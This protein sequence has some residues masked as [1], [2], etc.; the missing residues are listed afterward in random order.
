MSEKRE[1]R[2]K[3]MTSIARKLNGSFWRKRLW[4]LLLTDFIVAALVC[5][6]YLYSCEKQIYSQAKMSDWVEVY[7]HA[8]RYFT[9]TDGISWRQIDYVIQPAEM[10]EYRFPVTDFLEFCIPAAVILVILQG[11]HL[12]FALF[13]T[14]EIRRKLKPINDLAVRAE[15]MSSISFD[16]GKFTTLEHAI[17]SISPDEPEAEVHTGDQDLQSIEVA[18][19]NLLHHM[20]ESQQQ[21]ARFVSDASH[22]LRTP[23]AVIEGYVNLLDRWGKEDEAVLNESIEALKQESAHMK[24]LVEQLLFLA[25]GDSG[26]N[27]LHQ[28]SFDLNDVVKEVFEESMMIEEG[29]QY[30]MKEQPGALTRGDV[31]MIKQSIR[32]FV[33]NAVKYSGEGGC[34]TLTVGVEPGMVSYSVQD[35]G[36]GMEAGELEHIFERFYRADQARNGEKGGSGLG[37]SIARWIVEAHHGTI[38][39]TSAPECGSRFTVKL[40]AEQL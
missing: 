12:F 9:R 15:E 39:V 38:E 18:L 40:P 33:Q 30:K 36:V 6:G 22:E 21:Q 35:E 20:K 3:R 26:R 1:N 23:I 16:P 2:A 31:A 29:H 14:S 10:E 24:E 13:H 8:G 4:D 5:G 19:N 32:I 7:Q 25:R 28:V 27:T 11:I 17:E 37:L 34:I